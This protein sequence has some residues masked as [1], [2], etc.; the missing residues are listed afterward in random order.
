MKKIVFICC[1]AAMAVSC[2]SPSFRVEGS[3]AGA[4]GKTLYLDLLGL[5]KTVTLDSV[6]LKAD[7]RFRFRQQSPEYSELYR[8]RLDRNLLVFA[9]DS[10]EH[11]SVSTTSDSLT[12]AAVEGSDKTNQI[13]AL[14]KSLRQSPLDEHKQYARKVILSDPRSIVAYYALF[15]QKAGQ[16]VFDLYDKSDRPYFSAVA[17]AWNAFMPDNPRS[18]SVY[19][20][21]LDAIQQ[22]RQEANRE[23]MR[24]F[25][26]ASENS[27]LDISLM[28]ENGKL[29]YLSDLKGKPF[30]LDFSAIAMEKSSAYIFELR[31]LYNRF[32]PKGLEIYSVSADQNRLLWEDSAQNLPWI[33]V[34]GENA[35]YEQCFTDYNVQSIPTLFLFNKRG[36]IEGRYTDFTA[37][38]KAIEKCFN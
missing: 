3:I 38:S 14:R 25:I 10:A 1:V 26:A 15:Q 32:N 23:A 11:L 19:R 29:R 5:N 4:E 33:T 2:T 9:I 18:K 30:V 21:T 8:L 27:F 16:F 24:Q 7:G 13:T 34:R 12:Y 17:T 37:L 20:L 6:L 35:M 28:D 31:E 22:E 36:E